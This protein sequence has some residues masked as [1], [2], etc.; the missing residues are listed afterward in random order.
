MS[1]PF[2]FLFILPSF[3]LQAESITPDWLPVIANG[4]IGIIMFVVWYFTFKGMMGQL[5]SFIQ[6][7]L[8]LVKQDAEYK[9]LLSG[10][11]TR[12]ESKVD[13]INQKVDNQTQ[14]NALKNASKTAAKEVN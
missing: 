10:I 13:T 7:L 8:E 4:G 3:I 5:Q 12:L 6:S 1:F 11:L 9:S 2:S 14:L